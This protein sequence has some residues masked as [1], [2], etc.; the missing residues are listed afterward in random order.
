MAYEHREGWGSFSKNRYK[1][2]GDKKPELT[3]DGMYKGEIIR[4]AV[5]R[6]VR[7]D[8]RITFSF[9][10]Q[11]KEQKALEQKQERKIS[12]DDIPF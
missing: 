1:E 10:I 11:P 4:I 6:K 2:D 3:G 12:D 8:G 5:W 9:N 7:D